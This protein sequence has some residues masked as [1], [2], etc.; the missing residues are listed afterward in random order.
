[1]SVTMG[2]PICP[3]TQEIMIEPVMDHEGNTY[4]T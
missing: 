2:I 4:E 3:I 1:M